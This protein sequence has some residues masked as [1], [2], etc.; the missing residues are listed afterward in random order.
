MG[1]KDEM[2]ERIPGEHTA[3]ARSRLSKLS[4]L[5]SQRR[6]TPAQRRIARYIMDHPK[7]ATFLSSSEL[8]MRVGV[9]QP[10][11][12]RLSAALGF[13]GYTEFQEELR[14]IA[15]SEDVE[16]REE[17]K[18]QAAAT[19]E[20]SNL[21]ALREFL[22]NEKVIREVGERLSRSRPLVVLGLRA[23]APVAGYFAYFASKIHPEVVLLTTGGSTAMDRL[24]HASQAGASWMLC[25]LMPRHPRET[26]EI[27]LYAKRLGMSM[28]TVTDRAPES[29]VSV[30]DMILPAEVGTRLVFDSQAAAMVLAGALLEAVSDAAPRRSQKRLEDFERR[31]AEFKWFVTE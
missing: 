26:L 24:A 12:V 13:S 28:A 5:F 10:S 23:S 9:S 15:L 29:I 11:V 8:A 2:E 4:A 19:A 25:F 17:N 21:Y 14:K 31:A 20:I 16:N 30:S 18:F 22:R 6:L 3:V 27:M 7:E 1:K